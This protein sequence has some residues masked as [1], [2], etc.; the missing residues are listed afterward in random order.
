MRELDIVLF[1]VT[2]FAGQ[3]LAEYL[4]KNA[5]ADLKWGA[6]GRSED[7]V[8][9]V[10]TEV[11]A[12]RDVPVIVADSTDVESL[13]ELAKRTRVVCTTVGPYA[14]YGSG[15]VAACVDEGTDYCDLTGEVHWIRRM[16]DRHHERAQASGARIVHCCGFDSIPSDLGTL[17][18]QREFQARFGHPA[19]TVRFYLKVAKGGFSG[20]TIASMMNL[21]EEAGEDR[22]VRRVLVDPYSLTPGLPKGP[23]G[24]DQMGAYLD[25]LT[26]QWTAPF[27]MASVNTR[28]VRRSNALLDFEYGQDFSYDERMWTGKGLAG[29]LKAN[30]IAGGMVGFTG[31]AA[32]GPTRNLL[33][34]FLPKPG[35]GPSREK[36]D[37]G[38]FDVRFVATDGTNRLEAK[39]KGERDPGYGATALMLAESAMGLLESSG[40]GGILTPASAMGEGLIQRL[41]RAGMVFE[42][43]GE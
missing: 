39:V 17:M 7:K 1:G 8:R 23:D 21:M 38:Y 29:A 33:K 40:E 13:H 25:E 2:G 18:I 43:L 3:L 24:R 42:I 30:A 16:I 15:L 10:L 31:V 41:R 12:A 9:R 32:V 11:G 36:I 34:S 20:G 22:E 19:P 27:L 4:V 26:G 6:A 35:E 28:V 14:R 5:P 37:A